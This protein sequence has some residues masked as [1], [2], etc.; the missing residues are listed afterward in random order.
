SATTIRA[1]ARTPSPWIPPPTACSSRSWPGRAARRCSASCDRAG[2]R[3]SATALWQNRS[4]VLLF[5]AQVISLLGSGATTI[6]LAL[7]AC[8]VAGAT[9]ATIVVGNALMLRIVAFLLFSQPAGVLADRIDRK[10]ILVTSD[11]VRAV[12]LGLL[13]FVTTIWHV[14]LLIFTTNAVT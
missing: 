4:F 8:Q 14:Y 13:P 9:S 7:L 11:I 6:G 12:L 10:A 2:C 1:T 5:I 3:L